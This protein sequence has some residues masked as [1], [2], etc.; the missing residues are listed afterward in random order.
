MSY[1]IIKA[2]R[3]DVVLRF[4]GHTVNTEISLAAMS[5]NTQEETVTSATIK[6]AYWSANGTSYWNVNRGGIDLLQLNGNG[7][8][9]YAAQGFV[10][11]NSA[12]ANVYVTG[13]SVTGYLIVE[14]SKTATYTRDLQQA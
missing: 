6:A 12:A 8:S 7:E 10:V 2:T 11:A 9:N 13:T 14:L 3:K 1:E 4:T 5:A